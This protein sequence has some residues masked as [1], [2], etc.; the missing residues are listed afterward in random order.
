MELYLVILWK[1][2]IGPLVLTCL[3][4]MAKVLKARKVV[5][6]ARAG[7]ERML[8]IVEAID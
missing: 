7:E 3:A 6:G 8:L 4:R 1:I 5:V 2:G